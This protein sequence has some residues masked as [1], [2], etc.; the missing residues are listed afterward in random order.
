MDWGQV[1]R[2]RGLL[3][4]VLEAVVGLALLG[5]CTSH[6]DGIEPS[7]PTPTPGLAATGCGNAV[8]RA[9]LPT[10]ARAGFTPP[11]QT[12]SY[13]QGARGDIIGILFAH[14]LRSP[15]QDGQQNKILW[16]SRVGTGS[17]PLKI[18]ASLMN[19]D[20]EVVRYVQDG[21]HQSVIDMPMAGCWRFDLTWWG[22]S[23]QLYVRYQG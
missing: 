15:Q 6:G 13:V 12:T 8:T 10:W 16:L 23:D 11:D 18:E 7:S 2:Q 21:P 9:P 22:Q 4:C 19:A 3:G 14:P 5:A 1:M 20:V 17:G